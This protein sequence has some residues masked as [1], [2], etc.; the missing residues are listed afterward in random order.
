V[1]VTATRIARAGF[2]APTP[3]TVVNASDFENT[4][5]T[6]I[7]QFLNQEIP[8]LV[9]SETP[10]TT[11]LSS[12]NAG[13]NFLDL[14]SLGA[15]RTLVL[16][17]GQRFVPTTSQGTTDTNVIPT[18]LIDHVDVVTGGASAAW[19]S[20]AVAGVVNIV[21]KKDL[22]GF[23]ANVQYGES[24][25]GDNEDRLLTLAYGTGFA[26]GKGHFEVASEYEDNG[27]ILHQ[28]DRP[29]ARTQ[30][31]VIANPL[32]GNGQPAELIEPNYQLSIATEGGVILSGPAAGTQF[33]PGGT[34]EPFIQG[35]PANGAGMSGGNG[36]NSGRFTPLETPLNRVNLMLRGSY[37]L[38]SNLTG[39]VNVTLAQ[40]ETINPYLT[41]AFDFGSEIFADNAYLPASI[42]SQ[43]AATGTPGFAFGRLN[44]TDFIKVDDT[45]FVQRYVA[46]VNGGFGNNWKW[47]AHAEYGL[48]TYSAKLYGNEITANYALAEDAVVGPT[49]QIVCRSTLISPGNGC[50]PINLFGYG[51][52][53]AAAL[54]YVMG[55]QSLRSHIGETAAAANIQGEPISSWAGPVS[56]AAGAEFRRETLKSEVDPLSES[57]AYLIGDPQP[58]E[59]SYNVKEGFFET[60]VPLARDLPLIKS[61]DLNGAVRE[62]DYSTSGTVTTWKVGVSYSMTDELRFRATRSRD[63]RAPNLS[64]LYTSKMLLFG[65]VANPANGQS[66][67]VQE[68]T[69]GNASLVPEEADTT[70]GGI[71]YQP[72]WLQGFRTSVDVYQIKIKDAISQLVDQ[73]LVDRCYEGDAALCA[74]IQRDAAG[75]PKTLTLAYINSDQTKTSGADFETSYAAPMSRFADSWNGNLS[76]RLLATY[77]RDLTTTD[78]TSSENLAGI[79]SPVT[80]GSAG[81]PHWRGDASAAYSL[82]PWVGFLE[83]RFIGGGRYTNQFTVNDDKVSEQLVLN[84][85]LRYNLT[86]RSLKMQVY[87]NVNNI[88]NRAPPIDPANFIEPAQTNGVLYDV[89]GRNF[90]LGVRASIP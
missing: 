21:L 77:V 46:G 58:I 53:S 23:Q 88:F 86:A 31:G 65:S 52:P 36:V 24:Q 44:T 74:Y 9:G 85:S 56:I 6:N 59:G 69:T 28:Y 83:E 43:L 55:T 25:Y 51:S 16:L 33:G 22:Q 67:T 81:V 15:N 11:G 37:D 62:T 10:A 63:I 72:S 40:S 30:Y 2:N 18:A 57:S 47:D 19:G 4:A 26:D 87:A 76:L 66:F 29:W 49:G 42:A 13:G 27:G 20:D 70:T 80:T 79:L 34:P 17:D 1:V 61:L 32:S 82:G 35:N 7:G 54:N 12:Q 50:V 3:T 78:G 71:V 75:N 45:N 60:V 90:T 84:G 38:A 5:A 48:T 68:I 39:Y 89:V 73:D 64:E 14:R 41:P 8:A